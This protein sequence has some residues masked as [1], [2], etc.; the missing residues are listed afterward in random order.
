MP[1]QRLQ[2]LQ[3]VYRV[4][5]W[6]VV[7]ANDNNNSERDR[8]EKT[9]RKSAALTARTMKLKMQNVKNY[10]KFAGF[11]CLCKSDDSM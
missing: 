5:N 11:C 10:T 7:A 6:L 1:Q 9:M 3:L 2:L 4:I 8:D